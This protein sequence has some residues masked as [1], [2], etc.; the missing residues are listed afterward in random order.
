MLFWNH[1]PREGWLFFKIAF[2]NIVHEASAS[3]KLFK[4]VMERWIT[5]EDE[6]EDW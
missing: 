6:A 4:K 5:W 3:G 2:I 1:K